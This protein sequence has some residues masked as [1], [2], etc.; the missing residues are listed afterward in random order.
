MIVIEGADGAGKSTLASKLSTL[1]NLPVFHPGGS[2]GAALLNAKKLECIKRLK[3]GHILDRVT[4]ISEII[5]SPI[6]DDICTML[7][8]ETYEFLKFAADKKIVVIYCRPN[9]FE[10]MS[11]N[12]TVTQEWDTPD[13]LRK[14]K[15]NHHKIVKSYDDLFDN[16]APSFPNIYAP[17]NYKDPEDD[18]KLFEFIKKVCF[19]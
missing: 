7:R 16:W 2:P 19:T 17:Y 8:I 3:E 10:D 4:H 14:L 11:E 13:Y 1:L 15:D 18:K 12:M 9:D 5:Y 6:M